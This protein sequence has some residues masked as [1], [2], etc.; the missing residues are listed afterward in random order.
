MTDFNGNFKHIYCCPTCY[1]VW[2]SSLFNNV[3][4]MLILTTFPVFILMP[5][6]NAAWAHL[7]AKDQLPVTRPGGGIA[8]LPVFVT[9]DTPAGDLFT[10]AQKVTARAD[11]P[12]RCCLSRW[13]IPTF[14]AYLLAVLLELAALIL[15]I[16]LS[17]PPRG[18]VSFLGS[19]VLYNRLRASVHLDYTPIFQPQEACNRANKYYIR[20]KSFDK[21]NL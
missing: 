15:R 10:F 4:N 20:K 5:L 16:P 6:G 7:R 2:D 9:D 21:M 11:L 14:L 3:C 12:P 18:V 8:G 1:T 19:T 17:V 13:Y